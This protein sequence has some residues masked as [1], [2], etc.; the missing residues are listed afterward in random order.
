[1]RHPVEVVCYEGYRGAEKPKQFTYNGKTYL[2]Q[3]ILRRSVVESYKDRRR[4][5]RYQVRCTDGNDY[6]L[7][8]DVQ[9][10]EWFLEPES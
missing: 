3:S 2:I 6:E 10:H 4:V 7:V 8:F 5:Y 9:S 1:M